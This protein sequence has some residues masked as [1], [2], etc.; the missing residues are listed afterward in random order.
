MIG[1]R[2]EGLDDYSTSLH[3]YY[4]TN[5][6]NTVHILCSILVLIIDVVGRGQMPG[7]VRAVK[8]LRVGLY[9]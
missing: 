2:L 6:Y 9:G 5:N 3:I 7:H 1:D 4:I 8:L